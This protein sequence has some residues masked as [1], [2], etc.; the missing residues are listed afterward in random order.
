MGSTFCGDQEREVVAVTATDNNYAMPLAVTIRSAL[1]HLGANRRM[2]LFI[3]DGGLSD[4]SKSRLLKSWGDV[5]LR[6]EWIRPDLE[7]VRDLFVS[8]QVTVITYLR[9]LL[10]K[11]LPAN[12]ARVV[13]LDADMLIRRDLGELWDENQGGHAVLAVP[14]IAAPYIDA[15]A[16][17]TNFDRCR[18]HLCACTPIA[19]YRELGLPSDAQ[20]F[21]G[22]LLVVD[23]AQWREKNLSEQMLEC[24]HRYREHVLWWD[25]YALNVVLARLWRPLDYRWNQG[26]H[27]YAYPSWRE[28]PLDC[29]TFKQ[30]RKSPWIVHFCSPN[31]PW[32]Y[33]CRHPFRHEFR[34][35]LNHTAWKGWRP[36]RPEDY[37]EQWWECYYWPLHR[38]WKSHIRMAKQHI[39]RQPA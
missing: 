22:G 1:N 37:F 9:L 10:A 14:D 39:F 13:Y 38:K 15:N 8:H 27:V 30:L 7:E 28:S 5:R 17:M 2:R 19:N 11:I 35:C 26:T 29:A 34:R 21:N 36:K 12:V 4:E 3:L 31:K 6:V 24:L 32:H 16:V 18:T 20:Y 23:V 25:Q 33:F